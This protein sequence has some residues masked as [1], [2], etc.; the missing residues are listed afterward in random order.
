MCVCVRVLKAVQSNRLHQCE[1]TRRANWAS[2]LVFSERSNAFSPHVMKIGALYSITVQTLDCTQQSRG[3]CLQLQEAGRHQLNLEVLAGT[4][5]NTGLCSFSLNSKTKLSPNYLKTSHTKPPTKKQ[6]T[7]FY[8]F[9]KKQ[10][11]TYLNLSTLLESCDLIQ[12]NT[13]LTE[14]Q[15]ASNNIAHVHNMAE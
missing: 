13:C 5:I 8:A 2:G 9:S 10:L 14:K 3:C 11:S 1:Q 12:Q 6:T 4:Y 15:F 7:Y